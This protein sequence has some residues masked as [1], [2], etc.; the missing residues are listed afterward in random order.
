MKALRRSTSTAW[1]L[2]R[3]GAKSI[4]DRVAW[5]SRLRAIESADVVSLD[6]FDT[7]LLKAPSLDRDVF[8]AVSRRI[9][10]NIEKLGVHG[11]PDEVTVR[12]SLNRI[13]WELMRQAVAHGNDPAISRRALYEAFFQAVATSPLPN[14]AA[15]GVGLNLTYLSAPLEDM[16]P[17]LPREEF[18][19]N[20][21]ART[22][23]PS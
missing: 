15:L 3:G 22:V 11:L 8:V 18:E 17:F 21:I 9:L 20:V 23:Q 13:H 10:A 4:R 7:L 12:A 16:F 14:A 19:S 2:L 5:R 6:V 1:R